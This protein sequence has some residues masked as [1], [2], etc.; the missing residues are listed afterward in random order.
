MEDDP[1]DW[2]R[3]STGISK[4]GENCKWVSWEGRLLEMYLNNLRLSWMPKLSYVRLGGRYIIERIPHL[5]ERC[6]REYGRWSSDTE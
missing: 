2:G 3:E 6:L 5:M 4:L 1:Q